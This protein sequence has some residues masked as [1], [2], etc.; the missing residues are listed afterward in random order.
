MKNQPKSPLNP[1]IKTIYIYFALTIG[2]IILVI[3]TY[4]F[5]QYLIKSL[6]FKKYNLGYDENRCDYITPSTINPPSLAPS[7]KQMIDEAKKQAD[8]EKK[9]C[10]QKLEEQRS[11]QKILDLY[12]SLSLLVIGALILGSHYW[13]LRR[14]KLY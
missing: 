10:L 11:F 5:S 4:F 8:K 7:D 2:L 9:D 3:G 14:S 6:A 1:L 13:I 12:S